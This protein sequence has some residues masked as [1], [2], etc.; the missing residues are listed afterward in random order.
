[1]VKMFSEPYE[2]RSKL[3]GMFFGVSETVWSLRHPILK[4]FS[5]KMTLTTVRSKKTNYLK[6]SYLPKLFADSDDIYL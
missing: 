6:F 5:S 4:F 3:S 1:M 2:E